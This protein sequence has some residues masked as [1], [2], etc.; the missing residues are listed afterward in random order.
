MTLP[1]R[2]SQAQA[3]WSSSGR[4]AGE[5]PQ[6]GSVLPCGS[7][8]RA[9]VPSATF[10]EH[11]APSRGPAARSA[12]AEVTFRIPLAERAGLGGPSN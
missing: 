1:R 12:C 3:V 6:H 10:R 8:H 5:R 4:V 2:T 11:Y 7:T 9:L